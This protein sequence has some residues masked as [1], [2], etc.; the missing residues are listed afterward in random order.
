[1]NARTRAKQENHTESFKEDRRLDRLLD[2]TKFHIGIYLSIGGG[3]VGLIGYASN[4]ESRGFLNQFIGS[5]VALLVALFLMIC[6]GLAGGII[7]SCCTQFHTFEDVWNRRQGP[8]KCKIFK[9]ET[10]ASIEH[11]SFWLSLFAFGYAIL[12]A[13]GVLNWLFKSGH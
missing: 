2:Y 5:R 6:S 1:M 4:D 10:W 3:L 8:Y 9:G 7:A 12:S 13:P 11:F